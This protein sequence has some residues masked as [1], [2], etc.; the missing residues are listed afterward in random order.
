MSGRESGFLSPAAAF[1]PTPMDL[2]MDAVTRDWPSMSL[3]IGAVLDVAGDAPPVER[4]RERVA[5]CLS[6][7]PVLTHRLE[8]PKLRARWVHELHPDLTVRVR[9]M[10]VAPGGAAAAVDALINQP[11]TQDGPPWDLWLLRGDSPG[12]HTLCYRASHVTHDGVAV[13]NTLYGLLGAEVPKALAPRPATVAAFARVLRNQSGMLSRA[14]VW[15]DPDVP[16]TGELVR[17]WASVPT[18]R[19]RAVASEA[20][21][22]SNDASLAVLAGA[23]RTWAFDN[24]SRGA[25]QPLSAMVM[26]DGRH[27]AESARPGNLFSFGPL[28]LPAHL[29]ETRQR[30]AAVVEVTDVLRQPSIRRATRLLME[31]TPAGTFYAAAK[32]LTAP[33]RAPV[34]TSHVAFHQPLRHEDAPVT[35]VRMFTVL[36]ANHPLS[37]LS[38][39]YG[40]TTTLHFVAD[41]ALPGAAELPSRWLT[42]LDAAEK[43]QTTTPTQ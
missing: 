20:G 24:W 6:R 26:V 21:G 9:E 35:G 31:R 28:M 38:C 14:G 30:L 29:S 16:L 18:E 42:E 43:E 3:T 36:P 1:R 13:R 10:V 40:G 22:S 32:M 41:G 11:L 37:V 25:D 19:L 27:A 8:G 17:G 4:L 34:D 15:N 7:L 39:S 12:C 33:H 2:S 5:T 23:L